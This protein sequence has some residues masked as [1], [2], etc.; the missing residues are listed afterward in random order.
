MSGIA[1]RRRRALTSTVHLAS[2]VDHEARSTL[3]AEPDL[4]RCRRPGRLADVVEDG[5]AVGD[6]LG[7]R[8]RPERVPER[9]HVR[10]GADARDS[11]RGPTFRRCRRAPRGWRTSVPGSSPGGGSRRRCRRCPRPRSARQMFGRPRLNR[12]G[13]RRNLIAKRRDVHPRE[14]LP[15]DEAAAPCLTCCPCRVIEAA[16]RPQGATWPGPAPS[17]ARRE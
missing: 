15:G 16:R 12:H 1:P 17:G 6:G 4:P 3:V 9:V 2:A 10:V 5:R 7:V 13:E 11:G 8:P 14:G